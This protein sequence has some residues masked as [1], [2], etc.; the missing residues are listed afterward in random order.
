MASK[1]QAHEALSLF[2]QREGVPNIMVM[3]SSKKQLLGK[4]GHKCQQAGLHIKQIESYT[5]W[6]N[7]AE[8]AI[9]ELK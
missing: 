3:D 4:F 7:A 2:H 6:L 1:S 5:P 9:R 8:G